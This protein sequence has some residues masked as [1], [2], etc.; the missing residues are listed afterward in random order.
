MLG[1]CNFW[2]FPWWLR[3]W[4]ICLQCGRPELNSW[5]GSPGE[6]NSNPLQY[7][8]W[9]IQWTEAPGGLQS[10]GLR[11]VGHDWVTNS[12]TFKSYNFYLEI[13]VCAQSFSCVWLFATP[14]TVACQAPLSMEFPGKNTG[15]GCHFLLQ[16]LFPTQ[17]WNQCLL[18]LLNWQADCLPL[19]PPRKPHFVI[20]FLL[21][22]SY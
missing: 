8:A 10:M 20:W 9:I 21:N 12:F 22:I 6:G 14:W 13:C 4:R 18:L 3:R 16:G 7:F 2:R 1:N 19:A 17:G 15:V 11:A 5:V